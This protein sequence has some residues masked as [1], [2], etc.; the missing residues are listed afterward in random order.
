MTPEQLQ[1]AL[2]EIHVTLDGQTDLIGH[3]IA[4]SSLTTARLEVCISLL[5]DVL[6]HY[7]VDKA[8]TRQKCEQ[9]LAQFLV[10][11]QQTTAQAIECAENR[12]LPSAF[13]PE[14]EKN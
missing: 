4:Q 1:I 3:L 14:A 11:A 10:V 6:K 12:R 2:K 5:G 8:E 13:G 9:L 7:G